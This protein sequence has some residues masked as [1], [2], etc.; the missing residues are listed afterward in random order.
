MAS[1]PTTSF[2]RERRNFLAFLSF[3]KDANAN[4]TSYADKWMQF[5]SK[6]VHYT[7]IFFSVSLFLFLPLLC[8][9]V[10]FVS[11]LSPAFYAYHTRPIINRSFYYF[12]ILSQVGLSLMIGGIPLKLLKNVRL[13]T[14]SGYY[15][16]AVINGAST[17]DQFWASIKTKTGALVEHC[18]VRS[19]YVHSLPLNLLNTKDTWRINIPSSPQLKCLKVKCQ[20]EWL[21]TREQHL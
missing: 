5:D 9:Q 1:S 18:T 14:K 10:L 15:Q 2:T 13:Q 17:V 8:F 3:S 4:L 20:Y 11:F 19:S 7:N 21:G 12:F 16:R 6:C